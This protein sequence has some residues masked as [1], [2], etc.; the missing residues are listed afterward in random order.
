MRRISKPAAGLAAA[1]AVL[2][3]MAGAQA[4]DAVKIGVLTDMS[5]VYSDFGGQGSVVAAELAIEDAGG[6]V[7]GQPVGLVSA[8]HQNK[9]DIGVTAALKWFD[10]E[11]V[12]ALFDVSNSGISLA[13][14]DVIMKR[15]KIAVFSGANNKS[16]TGDRCTTNGLIWGYDGYALAKGNVEGIFKSNPGSSWFFLTVDYASGHGLEGDTISVIEKM[17]GSVKGT[18]RF[19]LGTTDFSSFLLQAQASGADVVA[20]V[21][22]G[23]DVRNMIKQA[24]E[25]GI[26][27][28]GQRI[29]PLFFTVNDIQGLGLEA[30]KGMPVVA[31]FY[32]DQNDGTRAFAE[33]FKARH[34][35]VPTDVQATVYSSVLHYLKAVEAAGTTQTQAVLAKMKAMPVEDFMTDGATIR[36]D[37][38]LMRDMYYFEVKSPAESTYPLDYLAQKTTIPGAEAY[39]PA[40]ESDCP[41]LK[42]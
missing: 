34:G 12:Q 32:W 27:Q 17:G 8:D 11:G 19:P 24:D 20:L 13:L 25:F 38:R 42:P 14:Q 36:A 29:A 21:A 7:L 31:D 28:A 26:A 30:T 3:Q 18:V 39:R 35:K 22:G 23:A 40:A 5:S 41:L 4:A 2:C 37:G 9:A 6:K 16:L 1:L 10:D 15:D 33:R